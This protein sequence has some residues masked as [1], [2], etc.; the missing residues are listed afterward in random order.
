MSFAV[1]API[2]AAVNDLPAHY[3]IKQSASLMVLHA[4]QE[5]FGFISPEALEWT[6]HKLQMQ[7]INLYELVTFY[8][9]FNLQP[10]GRFHLK[11]CRAL[12]CA[13]AG[14]HQLHKHICHQ[15]GP[16][17][18]KPG[19]QTTRDGRF[20]VE[21]VECPARCG[22][23]PVMMCNAELHECVTTLK[24]DKILARYT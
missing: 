6:A 11:V 23:A 12:S 22:T 10:T 24:A 21:L 4:L 3:P 1:P 13:L 2:E 7:P 19:P 15:L 18:H 5:H 14:S 9:M 20:T 16:D 17:H 8:P